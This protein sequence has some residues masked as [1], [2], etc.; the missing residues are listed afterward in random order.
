MGSIKSD[1]AKSA[2]QLAKQAAK[3]AAKEPFEILSGTGKQ[4]VGIEAVGENSW[5]IKQKENINEKENDLD[6]Q[7][8]KIQSKRMIEALEKEIEDIRKQK[9][10]ED[11][12]AQMLEEQEKKKVEE[13]KILEA[14]PEVSSR[15][16]RRLMTGMKG[17]LDKLKRKSEIRMPP[18][19]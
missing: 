1:A 13:Q 15:P 4:F 17:K 5:D 8:D 6:K 11:Q 18:S 2:K 7:K 19:G 10:R 3:Q 14:K 16:S 9:E 12:E